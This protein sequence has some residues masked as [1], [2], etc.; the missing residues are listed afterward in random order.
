MYALSLIE[1]ISLVSCRYHIAMFCL[2][3]LNSPISHLFELAGLL[4]FL[5]MFYFQVYAVLTIFMHLFQI[6]NC[7]HVKN[8]QK[9]FYK[10]VYRI[11]VKNL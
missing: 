7:I 10:N 4:M 11:H 2:F 9:I 3:E 8:L 6:I 1:N 5:L